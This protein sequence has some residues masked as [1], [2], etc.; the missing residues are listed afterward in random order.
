MNELNPQKEAGPTGIETAQKG[1]INKEYNQPKDRDCVLW[2][3]QQEKQFLDK[4]Y[5]R[6]H[7]GYSR[8]FYSFGIN[9][10]RAFIEETKLQSLGQKEIYNTLDN[11]VSWLD[12]KGTRGKTIVG[13]VAGVRKFLAFLDIEV[14]PTKLR[15]KVTMPKVT[16]IEEQP[17]RL[18][19]IRMVLTKGRPNPKMRA[20]ILTL[21]SSG[22]RIGEALSLRLSDLNLDA[23]PATINIRAEYSKTRTARVAYVSDEARDALRAIAGGD[24]DRLVF[25]YA[26]DLW[27]RS[28]DCNRTFRKIIARAGV[29]DMI[30]NHRIHTIHF[31]LFRKFFLTKGSDTI[32]EHAAH[33]LCGHGFYMDTYYQKSRK[34][35]EDD[36]LRLMP[37]LT[38]F[39]KEEK[40]DL[41]KA[42]KQEM[43]AMVGFKPEEVDQMNIEQLSNEDL[44]K[45]VREKLLGVMTNNGSKQKVI[46]IGEVESQLNQGW[47]FVAALPDNKAILKL[48]F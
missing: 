3:P 42:F 13:Y 39:G 41:K 1:G 38:V 28:K 40:V 22:M 25:H 45:M 7:S 36:Y 2:T 21:L 31:H 44:Q 20:L 30:H 9:S 16:K 26:G 46:A 37:L 17:L 15:S 32:G 33:A 19:D 8:R 24:P 5:R 14:D 29:D 11:W 6:S 18:E 47:E 4:V 43:L 10:F 12:S 35:R 23:H 34:E 48:P 27:Q